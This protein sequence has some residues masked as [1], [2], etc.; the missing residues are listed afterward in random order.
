MLV[1]L[2][3]VS[4][5]PLSVTTPELPIWTLLL[6]TICPDLIII[7]FGYSLIILLTHC[8]LVMPYWAGS[9]LAQVMAW[10]CQ[11]V[12]HYLKQCRSTAMMQYG[13]SRPQWVNLI[14]LDQCFQFEFTFYVFSKILWKLAWSHLNVNFCLFISF[15]C[16]SLICRWKFFI[17]MFLIW[18][19]YGAVILFSFMCHINP[20]A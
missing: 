14:I 6:E 19:L 18:L 1:W 11:T 15:V 20:V 8:G 17:K 4:K 2:I 5:M 13:I 10:C 7:Y 3:S 9:T 12:S 16:I